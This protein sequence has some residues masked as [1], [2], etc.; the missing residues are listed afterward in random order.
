MAKL[1][2]LSDLHIDAAYMRTPEIPAADVCVVAGDIGEGAVDSVHWLAKNIRPAMPVVFVLGNHEFYHSSIE[3]ERVM[4]GRAAVPAGVDVL[5]DMTLTIGDTRFIGSTLWTD[6]QLYSSGDSDWSS[7]AMKAARLGL[8]DHR[9]IAW[10]EGSS[11][12]FSPQHAVAM[13]KIS[14]AWIEAELAKPFDG[15]TVVVTHHAPHP[16]STAE[17]YVGDPLTPAF[18]S[19]LTPTIEAGRPALWVHGHMHNGADYTV[20]ETRIIANPRGYGGENPQFDIGL[21]ID[22]ADLRPQ[23][24]I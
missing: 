11:D 20:G 10:R 7:P 3:R 19:D 1:W 22:T 16:G 13:H 6:Y 18:A 8:N 21:V 23:L 17:R 15:E 12:R 24:S 9:L 5:D 2:I 4:A 14:R